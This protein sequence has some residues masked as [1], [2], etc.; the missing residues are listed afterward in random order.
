MLSVSSWALRPGSLVGMNSRHSF[1][2]GRSREGFP[3]LRREH[4]VCAKGQGRRYATTLATASGL[5]P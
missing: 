4:S 1:G 3:Q 2:S 5:A